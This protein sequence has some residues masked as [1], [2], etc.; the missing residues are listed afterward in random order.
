MVPVVA[1]RAL[2]EVGGFVVLSQ[3]EEDCTWV[4]VETTAEVAV[5]PR[6][7]VPA[8][9]HGRSV[10][11]IREEKAATPSPRCTGIQ[12]L[13]GNGHIT[14]PRRC[15]VRLAPQNASA[16]V[17]LVIEKAHLLDGAHR[18]APAPHQR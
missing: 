18:R 12:D 14:R 3:T 8:T 15:S 13:L 17:V 7:G 2:L 9:G 11:G 5:C 1:P 4:L 6:W 16:R 10:V